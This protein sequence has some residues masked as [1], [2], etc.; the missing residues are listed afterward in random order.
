M[1][2]PSPNRQSSFSC[3]TFSPNQRADPTLSAVLLWKSRSSY[4]LRVLLLALLPCVSGCI[5]YNQYIPG[6]DPIVSKRVGQLSPQQAA[7]V[8][9][10]HIRSYG[11]RAAKGFTMAQT[12]MHGH[13]LYHRQELTNA[14]GVVEQEFWVVPT[15]PSHLP[16][17]RVPATA[18][19]YTFPICKR[20]LDCLGIYYY[21]VD[22]PRFPSPPYASVIVDAAGIHAT[23]VLVESIQFVGGK[24][25]YTGEVQT[26]NAIIPVY[27]DKMRYKVLGV[28]TERLEVAFDKVTDIK[29][30]KVSG[31][32]FYRIVLLDNAPSENLLKMEFEAAA[33]L[34][35][36]KPERSE[37]LAAL[38]VLC[39]NLQ[40]GKNAPASQ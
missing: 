3:A 10:V 31:A 20:W 38:E 25:V 32:G 2:G 16:P 23:N 14:N 5:S 8:V 29:I 6:S 27:A 39:R 17:D 24:T 19:T 11:E 4:A 40:P 9:Q 34:Y 36:F 21:H 1:N 37:L 15:A 22:N 13:Q 33:A 12:M 35:C 30:W 26:P 7:S 28:R 18:Q